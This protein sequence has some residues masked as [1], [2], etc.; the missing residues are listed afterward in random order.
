MMT[1]AGSGRAARAMRSAYATEMAGSDAEL[2]EFLQMYA[3]SRPLFEA[4][5]DEEASFMLY[6]QAA[7]LGQ[8]EPAA[9]IM[10]RL[11]REAQASFA[12]LGR[13]SE[14]GTDPS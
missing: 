12:R 9:E 3:L 6:G 4:A 8:A 10:A 5:P 1:D 13:N 7:A 11:V 14:M 2:P